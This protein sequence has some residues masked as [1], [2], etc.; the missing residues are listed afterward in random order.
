VTQLISIISN[1]G[2]RR[3]RFAYTHIG[4]VEEDSY[5]VCLRG[6]RTD[7]AYRICGGGFISDT[8]Y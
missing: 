2:V 3:R 8:S 4:Y 1:T 7:M 5:K 6:I